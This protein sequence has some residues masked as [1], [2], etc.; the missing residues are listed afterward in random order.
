[1][2]IIDPN[3]VK[4]SLAI[5]ASIVGIIFSIVNFA[6][7]KYITAK[8]TNNDLKHIDKDIEDIKIREKEYRSDL[9]NELTKIFKR[10][11]RIEKQIIRRDVVCEM[12]HPKK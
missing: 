1:M 4:L 10:L 8:I 5:I 6:L 11:G 3:N 2:N 9:K 12:N 7:G